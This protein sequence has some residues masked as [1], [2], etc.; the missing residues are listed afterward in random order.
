MMALKPQPYDIILM[1]VA[2]PELDGLETTRRIRAEWPPHEQPTIIAL[3]ANTDNAQQQRY[4][5]MGMDSWLDKAAHLEELAELLGRGEYRQLSSN[6]GNQ[7]E[8]WAAMAQAR[9]PIDMRVIADLQEVLG[10]D[11]SAQVAELMGI[12]LGHTG[13]FFG[14]LDEAS[15]QGQLD[16]LQ[17][18]AHTLKSSSANLGAIRLSR[19]CRELELVCQ[20]NDLAGTARSVAQVS[21]ELQ[22][23]HRALA[24]IRV[25]LEA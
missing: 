16:K 24:D 1:D 14:Q 11:G 7:Q 18:I 6:P 15:R 9:S 2:M 20:S 13:H 17:H 22:A 23:V 4:L 10:S 19:L 25:G 12:F 21:E 8:A 3:S 5:A